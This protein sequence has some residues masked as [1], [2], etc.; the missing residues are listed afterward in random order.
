MIAI[1]F[2]NCYILY[3]ETFVNPKILP[4]IAPQDALLY[5]TVDVEIDISRFRPCAPDVPSPGVRVN[6]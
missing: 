5:K 3:N 2:L 6:P 1:Q 4:G